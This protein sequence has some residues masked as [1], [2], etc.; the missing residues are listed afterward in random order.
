MYSKSE[1]I[2][3]LQRQQLETSSKLAQLSLDNSQRILALQIETTKK[4]FQDGIENAKA[5]TEIRDI[6]QAVALQTRFAQETAQTMIETLR[7]IAEIGNASRD[8]LTQTLSAQFSNGGKE[9][10]GSFQSL[11]NTF[12]GAFQAFPGGPSG[13]LLDAMKQAMTTASSAMEQFT[14]ATTTS[15]AREDSSATRTPQTKRRNAA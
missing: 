12:P 3:E 2:T 1:Q 13:N 10:T 7:Q 15:F 11:F 9:M 14:K 8:E 4:L 6:Q 5:M